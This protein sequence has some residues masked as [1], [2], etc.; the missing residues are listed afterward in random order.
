V[1][2]ACIASAFVLLASWS[3][4]KWA[5]VHIDFGNELYIAWRLTEGD[6]LYH[7]I[8]YRNG[9]LAP[10][11]NGLWFFLFGVSIKTLVYCNL[12]ILACLSAM[13]YRLFAFSRGRLAATIATLVLLSVF[14]FSHYVGVANYNY[15]TPYQHGQTHGLTLS[16]AMIA[17]FALYLRGRRLRWCPLAGACLGLVFL[18]KAELLIPAAATA[19]LGWL[20]IA[21]SEAREPRRLF[22][23]VLL[24]SLAALAPVFAGFG[25]LWTQ[26]SSGLALQGVLGNWVYL[27]SAVA[28]DPFYLAGAGLDDV[29]GNAALALRMFLG[30][31]A[32]AALLV[33]ADHVIPLGRRSWVWSLAAG[34]PVFAVLLAKPDLVPWALVARALPLTSLVAVIGL[35]A[36]C[37]LKRRERDALARWGPLALWALW[38]LALLGKMILYARFHH[39]GFA[40]AM[41]ATL[42]LVI[43]LVSVL[44]DLPRREPGSGAIGRGIALAA[45]AA[46]VVFLLRWSDQIYARKD[47]VV[48]EGRDAILAPNPVWGPRGEAISTALRTLEAEMPPDATLLVLPEGTSLNYWLRRKSPSRYTLFVPA[49]FVAHGGEAVMLEDIRAR[50]PDFVALVHRR[51]EEFGVGPFGVDPL[52]GRSIVAWVR[53][54]YE[55]IRRIGAEPFQGRRF[56]IVILRRTP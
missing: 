33:A 19:G 29:S 21:A 39:Y 27:G 12:A 15:V 6:V 38:S 13:T 40:L 2:P 31:I 14:A 47:F 49:E 43:G 37:L 41:P 56:G 55:P 3:W 16:I 9:P 32:F 22:R 1:G 35:V 10:Y 44:P 42:L 50:P 52:N 34:G 30:L 23:L 53:E 20:L 17:A 51:H 24:F 4:D 11:V 18:T 54:N 46:G 7:D 36:L 45:V 8:A 25:L 48:G 5:D 28:G 26:M